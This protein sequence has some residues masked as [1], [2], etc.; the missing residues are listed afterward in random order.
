MLIKCNI[1]YGRQSGML[2]TSRVSGEV[3]NSLFV[4]LSYATCAY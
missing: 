2:L 1:S 4:F 3:M